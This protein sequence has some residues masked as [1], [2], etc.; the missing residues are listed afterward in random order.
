METNTTELEKIAETAKTIV[1]AQNELMDAYMNN[2]VLVLENMLGELKLPKSYAAGDAGAQLAEGKAACDEAI[3]AAKAKIEEA[4]KP[5][6][7]PAE[8]PAGATVDAGYEF[9]MP[10]ADMEQ[11]IRD[12]AD[13]VDAFIALATPICDLQAAL[14]AKV[15]ELNEKYGAESENGKAVYGDKLV[16]KFGTVISNIETAIGSLPVYNADGSVHELTDA[17]TADIKDAIDALLTNAD[18]LDQAWV[19]AD[20]AV[21]DYGKLDTDFKAILG[22]KTIIPDGEDYLATLK[23]KYEEGEAYTQLAADYAKYTADYAAAEA[24]EAQQCYDAMVE[25]AARFNKEELTKAFYTIEK[26]FD[27]EG[28]QLNDTFIGEVLEALPEDAKQTMFGG[29]DYEGYTEVTDEIEALNTEYAAAQA[30]FAEQNGEEIEKYTHAGYTS[31]DDLYVAIDTKVKALQKK[32][33]DLKAKQ[34]LYHNCLDQLDDL[35]ALIDADTAYN[36]EST[37]APATKF[38]T[39][40]IAKLQTAKD[41]LKEAIEDAYKA[42]ASETDN[43]QAKYTST[44]EKAFADQTAA[45]TDL[46]R[47]MEHNEKANTYLISLSNNVRTAINTELDALKAKKAAA[48]EAGDNELA[49]KVQGWIDEL[50]DLLINSTEPEDLAAVDV[51]EKADF[52]EGLADDNWEA[53]KAK[54]DA[55]SAKFKDLQAANNAAFQADLEAWNAGFLGTQWTATTNDLLDAYKQAIKTYDQYLYGLHNEG[56][57]AYIA[58]TLKDHR[59]IY[60]FIDAIN[61]VMTDAEAYVATETAAGRLI[62]AAGFKEAAYDKAETVNTE[63]T[64][65]VSDMEADVKAKAEEFY[66]KNLQDAQDTIARY[67]TEMTGYGVADEIASEALATQNTALGKAIDAEDAAKTDTTKK[68]GLEMDLIADDLDTAR[69]APDVNKA[70]TDTWTAYTGTA[71]EYA[72]AWQA[73]VDAAKFNQDTAAKEAFDQAIKDIA[74]LSAE[75]AAKDTLI[76]LT[77]ALQDACERA[78]AAKNAIVKSSQANEANIAEKARLDGVIVEFNDGLDALAQFVAGLAFGDDAV[79]TAPKAAVEALEDYVE[80]NQANLISAENKAEIVRLQTA[81]TN[82]IDQAYGKTVYNENEELTEWEGKLR[83]AYNDAK[84]NAGIEDFDTKYK[85]VKAYIDAAPAAIDA[86][87][88]YQEGFD[89]AAYTEAATELEFNIANYYNELQELWTKDQ[90]DNDNPNPTPYVTAKAIVDAAADEAANDMQAAY[91]ALQAS[92]NLKTVNEAEYNKLEDD[93]QE[94]LAQYEAIQGKVAAEGVRLVLNYQEYV[95]AY[96]A[97]AEDIAA[98]ATEV[99]AAEAAAK[100]VADQWAASDANYAT[101]SDKL[102]ALETEYE[103][104]VK[105]VTEEYKIDETSVNTALEKVLTNLQT[106]KTN[107]EAA[108]ANHTVGTELNPS[109]GVISGS[110]TTAAY[111]AAKAYA[112]AG[113]AAACTANGNLNEALK[114]NVVPSIAKALQAEQSGLLTDLEMY[115][116]KIGT[117]DNV[118]NLEDLRSE[119]DAITARLEEMVKEAA[120]N[121][122]VLGDVDLDPNGWITTTDVQL[123]IKWLGEGKTYEDLYEM[124]PVIAAAANV[125]GDEDVFNI[126]DITAEINLVMNADYDTPVAR[127][128]ARRTAAANGNISAVAL[129]NGRYAVAINSTETFVAGQID[130]TVP[131]GSEIVKAELVGMNHQLYQFDNN[132]YTRLIIASMSNEAL[133]G[134]QLLIIE[135]EGQGAPSIDNAIFSDA[136]ANAYTLG[137]STTGIEDINAADAT[138]SQRIY[139]AAGQTMRAIQRGINI[140]RHGDGSTT[141]EMHK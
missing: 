106:A 19:A 94:I 92:E 83:A 103:N 50:N 72:T 89:T 101:L 39:A 97:L 99:T 32:I 88:T 33:E 9:H 21:K 126:A 80:A 110:L 7:A 66:A 84:V 53:L 29:E 51:E 140:I 18:N 132:G 15:D 35:Q 68:Y 75:T 70:V 133:Q 67:Q 90:S 104:L 14:E 109:E 135:V 36:A 71:N 78:F 54:Y 136:N 49:T 137:S 44:F 17:E 124:S 128:F 40:E 25:L 127:V 102:E 62:N 8:V 4:Y 91:A 81:A 117:E 31:V 43:I 77:N 95:D 28:T 26:A 13:K 139:N 96:A 107:L 138:M 98:K 1:D 87:G 5:T 60:S 118:A 115:E 42:Y 64:T 52:A 47:N 63:I 24:L 10:I 122:F 2:G 57:K 65:E 11:E 116:N 121:V 112:D 114:K 93:F 12:L 131:E 86:L 22:D 130:I 56:Y 59:K 23:K 38:W 20:T 100:K 134:D 45:A 34:V 125:A 58:E 69:T 79:L 123:M 129:G 73:E 61:T 141:K 48:E 16:A 3:A 37:T 105:K 55:V 113:V 30:A 76:G 82:A 74:T 85:E 41:E 6:V 46:L 119:V 111:R 27:T 108:K 120:E